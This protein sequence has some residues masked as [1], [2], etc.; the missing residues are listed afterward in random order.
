MVNAVEVS[1]WKQRPRIMSQRPPTASSWSAGS[2]GPPHYPAASGNSAAGVKPTNASD[3]ATTKIPMD[4]KDHLRMGGPGK[5]RPLPLFDLVVVPSHPIFQTWPTLRPQVLASLRAHSIEFFS[6]GVYKRCLPTHPDE[7][8]LTTVVIVAPLK[9]GNSGAMFVKDACSLFANLDHPWLHI[10]LVD[11]S[12]TEGKFTFP[13]SASDSV[14]QLWP[15]L[16]D[17]IHGELGSEDW[18]CMQVVKRGYSELDCTTTVLISVSNIFDAKWERIQSRINGIL[19]NNN[20]KM[21]GGRFY[22]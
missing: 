10:E 20:P 5:L 6:I 14:V 13:T 21:A 4:T 22:E 2:G 1:R 8:A 19:N 17:Q 16:R 7:S 11:P 15:S 12:A 18:R 3:Q 9:E